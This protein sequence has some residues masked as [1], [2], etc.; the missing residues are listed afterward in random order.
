MTY[1]AVNG[2]FPDGT[3]FSLRKPQW[4]VVEPAYGPLDPTLRV[5]PRLAPSLPGAGLLEAIPEAALLARADPDDRDGDGI[6]GRPN[7]VRDVRSGATVMGR[8]GWKALQP[9]VRQQVA[10]A[11]RN[12]IGITSDL[13]AE[14][15]CSQA[16]EACLRAPSGGDLP[17]GNEISAF[18]LDALVRFTATLAVATRAH[19]SQPRVREGRDVFDRIGCAGCHTPSFV[20]D[21]A[22]AVREAGGQ[23]VWPY[24]DLL[25]HDMGRDLGDDVPE[26][27]ASGSEWR[28]AP[29]WGLGSAARDAT[30]TSLL[31]DGR[32][33]SVTEA[34]LWHGGEARR[35]RDAFVALP[36]A[37]REALAAFLESL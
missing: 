14:Q 10:S 7:L 12:D 16:Q 21:T 18:L 9:T 22:S 23:R 30:R 20:T 2:S 31:H 1:V 24:S 13:Y 3:S 4:R 36:R 37:Q 19:A 15:P 34:I 25:L 33:R 35:S 6:S 8:F 26:A 29:L 32:A 27:A 11:L 5:S 28:T 17:S